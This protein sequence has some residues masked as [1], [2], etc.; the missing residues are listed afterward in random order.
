MQRQSIGT[1]ASNLV[2]YQSEPAR[3]RVRHLA[4]KLGGLSS[5]I[6]PRLLGNGGLTKFADA[7]NHIATLRGSGRGRLIKVDIDRSVAGKSGW[8]Q[9]EPIQ[10]DRK[11]DEYVA[12]RHPAMSSSM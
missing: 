4:D 9:P 1:T 8:D 7:A 2:P 11:H 6:V 3:L 5:I 12:T 10:A